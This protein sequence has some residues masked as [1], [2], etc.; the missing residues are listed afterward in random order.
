MSE[1]FA[2]IIGMALVAIALA[3]WNVITHHVPSIHTIR[4]YRGRYVR[5]AAQYDAEVAAYRSFETTTERLNKEAAELER[6]LF[7]DHAEMEQKAGRKRG[8]SLWSG[9]REKSSGEAAA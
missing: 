8:F 3:I 6:E 9:S 7:P 4:M 5:A 2:G 1:A